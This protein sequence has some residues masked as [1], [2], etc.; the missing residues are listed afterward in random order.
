MGSTVSARKNFFLAIIIAQ[1]ILFG[2]VVCVGAVGTE[3]RQRKGKLTPFVSSC[4][5]SLSS[6]SSSSFTLGFTNLTPDSGKKR[7]VEKSLS[8]EKKSFILCFKLLSSHFS[9]RGRGSFECKQCNL[10]LAPS[11]SSSS[12]SSSLSSLLPGDHSIPKKIL[13]SPSSSSLSHS[14]PSPPFSPFLF[15]FPQCLLLTLSLEGPSPPLFCF[16]K[17]R[18]SPSISN[19]KLNYSIKTI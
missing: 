2:Q 17:D 8:G 9:C 11:S 1:R 15:L 3:K 12:S 18:H 5:S 4:T 7:T 14:S 13:F 6:S 19:F 16:H 10:F